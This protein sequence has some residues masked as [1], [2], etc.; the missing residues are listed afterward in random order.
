MDACV[1]DVELE[2]AGSESSEPPQPAGAL[3]MTM[4]AEASKST[5]RVEAI[6]PAYA[7]RSSL[8]ETA[9]RAVLRIVSSTE[10]LRR[11]SSEAATFA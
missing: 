6:A 3:A 8:D 5:K 2:V 1:E 10:R 9:P 7:R 4:L 11:F